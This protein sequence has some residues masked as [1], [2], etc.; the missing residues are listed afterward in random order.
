VLFLFCQYEL[1]VFLFWFWVGWIIDR[2]AALR[3]C[4]TACT[5]AEI[6]L[7]LALSTMMF[8]LRSR[9]PVFPYREAGPWIA[10]AWGLVILCYSLLRVS[11]LWTATRQPSH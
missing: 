1:M 10:M 6:I 5:I 3:D 7:G 2:T 11:N 8:A 9:V 4:G